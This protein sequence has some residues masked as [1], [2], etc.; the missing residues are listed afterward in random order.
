MD[1][2]KLLKVFSVVILVCLLAPAIVYAVP[3]VVTGD[4]SF[5]VLSDSMEPTLSR[6]DIVVVKDVA[7]ES[8]EIGDVITFSFG[9]DKIVTHRVVDI[10]ETEERLLFVTKGDAMTSEDL[11]PV[12]EENLIGSML[13]S[14]P[15]YGYLLYY[16]NSIY[17]LV[18]FIIVPAVLLVGMEIRD[19]VRSKNN[20]DGVE[21]KKE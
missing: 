6:G 1:R 16:V 14:I 11:N 15:F 9:E 20:D 10:E 19:M 18:L 13:F 7:P 5:I 21:V 4:H 3:M 8:V 2:S 17:G 12:L